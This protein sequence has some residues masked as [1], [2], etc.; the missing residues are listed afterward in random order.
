MADMVPSYPT[1]KDALRLALGA[2]IV[3]GLAL[4]GVVGDPVF[5]YVAAAAA[6]NEI[7]FGAIGSCPLMHVW[8]GQQVQP[9]ARERQAR[10]LSG[11]IAVASLIAGQQLNAWLYVGAL[12]VGI[13]YMQSSLTKICYVQRLVGQPR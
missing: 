12:L 8:L 11:S 1:E 13:D 3:L 9:T 6:L 10:L 5:L 2:M 7:I 4:S